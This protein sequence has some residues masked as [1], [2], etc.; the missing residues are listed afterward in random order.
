MDTVSG[1]RNYNCFHSYGYWNS[2]A[3]SVLVQALLPGGS[4]S[5]CEGGA[6]NPLPKD[7]KGLKRWIWSKLKSLASLLGTLG[8]KAAETLSGII[9]A[10]IS[11]ILNRAKDVVGWVLQNLWALAIGI[12]GLLY[13]YMVMKREH[14]K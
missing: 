9:G 8:V 3:I 4:G 5:G 1:T 6:G 2:Q 10:I 14:T 11:L 13:T 12:G 7:E